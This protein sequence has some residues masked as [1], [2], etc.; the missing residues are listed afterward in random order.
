VE[1]GGNFSGGVTT[2]EPFQF[3]LAGSHHDGTHATLEGRT[4]R[5]LFPFGDRAPHAGIDDTFW[6]DGRWTLRKRETVG[7][8]G[9]GWTEGREGESGKR[10]WAPSTHAD[11][12]GRNGRNW[13][14][15]NL[16]GG[17]YY[18]ELTDL[19]STAFAFKYPLL[20]LSHVLFPSSVFAF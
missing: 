17:H 18:K 19:P 14:G 1:I 10:F 6:M 8:A 16:K 3:A 9:V 7:D 5:L 4:V 13:R 2:N 15:G 11:A 20:L 12:T